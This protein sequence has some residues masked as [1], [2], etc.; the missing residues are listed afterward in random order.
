MC[1]GI[2]LSVALANRL[3]CI[4]RICVRA[5]GRLFPL[6]FAAIARAW[7]LESVCMSADYGCVCVLSKAQ[8]MPMALGKSTD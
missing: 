5:F 7:S 8:V 3:A 2:A 6:R 1:A 4:L